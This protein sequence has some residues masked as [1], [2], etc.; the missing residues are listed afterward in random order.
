MLRCAGITESEIEGLAG[1]KEGCDDGVEFITVQRP[2]EGKNQIHSSETLQLL[3]S[4][5][6]LALGHPAEVA[7]K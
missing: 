4:A 2:D 1:I 6:N 3:S 5:K 7:S